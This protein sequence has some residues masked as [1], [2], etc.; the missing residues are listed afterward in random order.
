MARRD[1]KARNRLSAARLIG[2]AAT[3]MLGQFA[4]DHPGGYFGASDQITPFGAIYALVVAAL[5]GAGTVAFRR[6]H[7]AAPVLATL[8]Y[9]VNVG[10]FI[11]L[12]GDDAVVAGVVVLWSL[13]QLSRTLFPAEV[14]ARRRGQ[15]DPLDHWLLTDGPAAEHLLVVALMITTLVIGYRIGGRIPAL[16]ICMAIDVLVAI[17]VLPFLRRLHAIGHPALRFLAAGCLVAVLLSPKPNLALGMI[18]ALFAFLLGLIVAREPLV[19]EVIHH[20]YRRPALLLLTSFV[21][22]IAIGTLFLSFPAAAAP[23]HTITPLDALFTATSAAC[24]T[25]LVVLDTASAFSHFGQVVILVLIQIG[26]L[27]IMVLSTFAGLM[28]GRNLGLMGE[29]ALGAVLDQRPEQ[30]SYPL[31]SFIVAFT[32]IVEALGA[33]ALAAAFALDGMPPITALWHGI[34][35]SVSAFCNAGFALHAD[36]LVRYAD[37]PFVLGVVGLLITCGG[38]GFAV[39]ATVWGYVRHGRR[40]RLT[41]QVRIVLLVSASL[42]L[43]G[44]GFY[45]VAE[46]HRS[47]AGLTPFDKCVN[48]LF[49]SV[50]LRTAGFNSVPFD[51]LHPAT[52]FMMLAFMF[53]GASPGGTGGG[54]KTTTLA[55]LLSAVPALAVGRARVVMLGRTVALETIY[56]SAAIAVLALLLT[57]FGG[58]ALMVSQQARFD[59]VLFETVSAIG[60]VGLSLGAT[61]QLDAFGKIAIGALMLF[62]RV[63]PLSAALLLSRGGGG[64]IQRPEARMMVG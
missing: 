1:T 53:V 26:G 32:A 59:V 11:P 34:F 19:R 18:G 10:A 63:G 16:A 20:F 40:Q 24:V 7:G 36:S 22:L 27:N 61:A 25:G 23:G 43:A 31:I 56:R 54:I 4:I 44:A 3:G 15:D 60:T 30:R 35:H 13:V 5:A 37:H 46:W 45:A 42:V 48:A 9:A 57:F 47:L 8:M 29:R 58:M 41:V 49:Q 21:G 51:Q 2:A 38:L 50:T 6:R 12:I 55:V 62:G 33:V 39:L 64:A 17:T 52:I 28:L 14:R